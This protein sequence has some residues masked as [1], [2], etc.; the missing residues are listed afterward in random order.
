[1]RLK[2]LFLIFQKEEALVRLS[3]LHLPTNGVV[4]EAEPTGQRDAASHWDDQPHE[5]LVVAT[6]IPRL[7]YLISNH[8]SYRT[9]E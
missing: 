8:M 4:E 9:L 7:P 1:M 2:Q 6:E 3:L 5:Q